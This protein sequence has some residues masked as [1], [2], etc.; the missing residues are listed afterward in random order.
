MFS[1]QLQ[2]LQKCHVFELKKM[3]TQWSEYSMLKKNT[4]ERHFHPFSLE[5]IDITAD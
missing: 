1:I 3:F 4:S 5:L 2:T